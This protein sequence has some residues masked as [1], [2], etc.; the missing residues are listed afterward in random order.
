MI[1]L[2]KI[3]S[4]TT[5]PCSPGPCLY[6]PCKNDNFI[7]NIEL[8]NDVYNSLHNNQDSAFEKINFQ[9]L[10][11][12]VMNWIKNQLMGFVDLPTWSIWWH[13]RK[14]S[15]L[16]CVRSSSNGTHTPAAMTSFFIHARRT[17]GSGW[18]VLK[19]WS[20]Q[21]CITYSSI[22]QEGWSQVKSSYH[23]HKKRT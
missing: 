10:Y 2:I 21:C 5:K 17:W 15:S 19:L 23:T 20:Q 4:F 18:V 22:C 8:Y 1:F 7:F 11:S 6:H 9:K 12:D 14:L 3:T 13:F 16:S